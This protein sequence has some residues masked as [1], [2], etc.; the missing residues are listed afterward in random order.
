MNLSIL[1]WFYKEAEVCINRLQIL[2][3]Y[4]SKLKIYGLYGGD[5]TDA[6]YYKERLDPYLDDFYVFDSVTNS[7]WKWQHGDLMLQHWFEKRGYDLPWDSVA[8]VQWD[9][10]VFDSL[11]NQFAGL[12]KDQIF[13]SGLQKLDNETEKNWY[14]TS[15]N[16]DQRQRYTDFLDHIKNEYNY[17]NE[18]LCCLFIFQIFPR[19]FFEKY[20]TVKERELGMLEYKIPI[21]ANIFG[22]P[23]YKKDMG[24]R[25]HEKKIKPLNAIPEEIPEAYIRKE[26]RKKKGWRVF[27]PYFKIWEVDKEV[28]NSFYS[29]LRNFFKTKADAVFPD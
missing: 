13:L 4:N 21:Y 6:G 28:S 26:L 8:V 3:Q 16:H 11:E 18:L 27:H 17:E 14:W 5:V 10:L 9:M 25:W 12:K 20:S 24:V 29:R 19:L 2:K 1:F 23:F 7:E 15:P 22:I